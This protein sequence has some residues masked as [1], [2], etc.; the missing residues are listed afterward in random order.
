MNKLT[1]KERAARYVAKIAGAVSGQGGHDATFHVAAMIWNG[2][3]LSESDTLDVLRE[4]NTRCVPPWSESEL[5]HKVNS[6]ATAQHR[7][8]RGFLLGESGQGIA[9]PHP[10]LLPQEKVTPPPKP[11]FSAAV[12]KRIA[13]KTAAIGDV[14]ASI[15]GRSPVVV[16]TQ[17][18]ASV[19]RRL[20][21][22]GSG[23]K[24]LIFST[25]ESQGQMLWEADK[26]DVIQNRHLPAG[27]DGV[28]FLPQ[29]VDGE[30][31]PNPRQENKPS[32]RSEESIADWRFAVLESDEAEPEDWL[33]CLVQMPLRIAC[34]C[35]S[36]G[37][38]I[39][40]LVR[41]D[42]SSKADWDKM[43]GSAKPLLITLGADRGALSAVRLT[44][45]PQAQ[46]GERIQR[47]LYLNPQPD[48][49]PILEQP[50][51]MRKGPQ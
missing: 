44:R 33:R 24:I 45:L 51:R 2:F 19:L 17:D 50:F 16:E 39:H 32:R 42:A 10:G 26:S 25:M 15:M 6:V 27:D 29:P 35:E 20:Y 22:F 7:D 18:S 3:G 49:V 4:W 21:P 31:H 23:E 5:V 36:G 30:F 28:W 48:G 34:V 8:A 40:A 13:A 38:S 43:I 14:V 9:R 1:D 46:R 11:E 47:L 41:V 37:R 12:L